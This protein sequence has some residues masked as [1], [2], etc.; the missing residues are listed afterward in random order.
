MFGLHDVALRIST[1]R[2]ACFEG[3]AC[4]EYGMLAAQWNNVLPL[5]S[6]TDMSRSGWANRTF[7]KSK[8]PATSNAGQ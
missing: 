3:D 7:S 2:N 1:A 5:A 6:H 4:F 8:L